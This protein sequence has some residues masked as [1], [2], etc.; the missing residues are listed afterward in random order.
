MSHG[1]RCDCLNLDL[2]KLRFCSQLAGERT[3]WGNRPDLDACAV[4][5]TSP[6]TLC[7]QVNRVMCGNMPSNS[8]LTFF[9][10]VIDA[11]H[12]EC[13]VRALTLLCYCHHQ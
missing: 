6:A 4:R 13:L 3:F 7:E 11:G 9:Y 12:V 8:F 5:Q 1:I 2:R 10:A